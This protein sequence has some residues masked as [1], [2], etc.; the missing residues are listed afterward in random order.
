MRTKGE[1]WRRGSITTRHSLYPGRRSSLYSTPWAD[2]AANAGERLLWP[3]WSLR[4]CYSTLECVAKEHQRFDCSGHGCAEHQPKGNMQDER[5]AESPPITAAQWRQIVNSA[6]DTAII[7]LDRQGRI[8]SWN[9]GA[10]RLLGWREPEMIGKTLERIFPPGSDQLEREIAG[11]IEHGRGGGEEGWR[12]RKDGGH[13]WGAGEVT[14]IRDGNEGVGFVK[15]LRDRTQQREA[16]EAVREERRALEVLNRAGSALSMETD[17]HRLVQIVTDAGVEL[18][19]AEFCAFF[20]NVEDERGES[21][22]LYT[23]SGAPADAF[24]KFPMPRNTEVFAPTFNGEGIVRSDDIT[25]D[26]R[27]GRNAPR[28]GMPEGHLPVRSYLAV[29]VVA[30]D[31]KVI[32]GLFFGHASVGVFTERSDRGLTGLAAEAAVA[33][34]NVYLAQAAQR[35]ISERTRAEEALRH[36][37]A[38]LE[39]EVAERTAQLRTNEEALR[40]AQKMEAV[41]QLTGGVAHDVG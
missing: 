41:G 35:E 16:E 5:P 9:A 34:D 21:Y 14:P 6:V 4:A 38:N 13:I 33:I 28:K 31:G 15:N 1:L 23:L 19:H 26:P 7:S 39:R 27:Y 17:L 36:L 22:M 11:A 18:T 20:Y 12:L 3:S 24:S 25:K 37:N 10:T 29:P 30:R 40:Q 32:G 8:T 2:Q